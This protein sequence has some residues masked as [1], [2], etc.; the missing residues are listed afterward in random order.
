MKMPK[1]LV[2]LPG[3]LGDHTV[4]SAVTALLD[5]DIE[6]HYGRI[7]LDD[8]IGS[9]ARSVLEAAPATFSLAGHSLGAIVALEI[10]RQ[11]PHRVVRLASLNASAMGPTS[12][13][14]ASWS[15]LRERVV[16]GGFASIASSFA[17]AS[18]APSRRM[19]EGLTAHGELMAGRVGAEG[20]LRQ[21]AV[22]QS[23]PDYRADLADIRVTT[24]VIGGHLDELATEARQLEL[25]AGI[26][27][28]RLV[29]LTGCG[30][31]SPIE[32]PD[33]VARA[34]KRWLAR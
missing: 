32:R 14:R 15:A 29:T 30:H 25:A 11:A 26:A 5:V 20:L 33:A 13:Q 1:P 34:F 21:L 19:D 6:L 8:D 9:V 27:G 18:L 22:Q 17:R 24:I 16:S 10:L 31:M 23:R 7:D 12:D 3:M 4:W 28:S 2:L